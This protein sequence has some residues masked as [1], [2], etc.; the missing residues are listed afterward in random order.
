MTVGAE[1]C[2]E[3]CS[4]LVSDSIGLCCLWLVRLPIQQVYVVRVDLGRYWLHAGHV[5]EY[6][7]IL[8]GMT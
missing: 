8:S 4:E 7:W 3:L 1:L 2:L 6:I 5:A